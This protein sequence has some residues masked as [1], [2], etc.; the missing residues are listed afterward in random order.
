MFHLTVD[1]TSEATLLGLKLLIT[2]LIPFIL[3][4]EATSNENLTQELTQLLLNLRDIGANTV[5]QLCLTYS[6]PQ[7]ILHIVTTNTLSGEKINGSVTDMLVQDL[8]TLEALC[9]QI[10]LISET[11]TSTLLMDNSV[12]TKRMKMDDEY[13]TTYFPNLSPCNSDDETLIL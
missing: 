12:P 2:D 5:S 8:A 10:K 13:T 6:I 4:K 7:P 1:K 3:T 11:L 9:I